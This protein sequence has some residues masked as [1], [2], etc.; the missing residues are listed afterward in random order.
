MDEFADSHSWNM[1]A[2]TLKAD[3]DWPGLIGHC[4]MWLEKYP[5]ETG[6]Q[7]L[8]GEAYNNAGRYQESLDLYL[9]VAA[10]RPDDYTAWY[11]LGSVAVKAGKTQEAIDYFSMAVYTN[12]DIAPAIKSTYPELYQKVKSKSGSNRILRLCVGIIILILFA[13]AVRI[14]L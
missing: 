5:E 3:K 4:Q 9:K 8:L 1:K 6:A 13:L 12:R 11:T 2:D 10:K 7:I 14:F